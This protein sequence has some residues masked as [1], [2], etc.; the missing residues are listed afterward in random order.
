MDDF[1]DRLY[2]E[3]P[4]RFFTLGGLEIVFSRD[5]AGKVVSLATSKFT[6]A[7]QP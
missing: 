4:T 1:T 5:A 3:T 6:L 2:P 7:R